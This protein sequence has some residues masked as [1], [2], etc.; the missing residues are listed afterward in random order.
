L[1]LAE[2][3]YEN[4]YVKQHGLWKIQHMYWAPTFYASVTGIDAIKFSGVGSSEALPPDS[5]GRE[6][7]P[8]VGR[9]LVPYHF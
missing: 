9:V 5:P 7:D 8:V 2:G 4:T 1:M 6:A 3:I